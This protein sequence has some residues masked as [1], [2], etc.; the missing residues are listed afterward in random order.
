VWRL[1]LLRDT[2]YDANDGNIDG[3]LPG[4]AHPTHLAKTGE[5]SGPTFY[6]WMY[7]GTATTLKMRAKDTAILMKLVGGGWKTRKKER[8]VVEVA[9][10]PKI[11]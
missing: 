3:L 1:L 4:D 9:P 7:P 11:R 5:F 10:H 8:G 6:E 2:L